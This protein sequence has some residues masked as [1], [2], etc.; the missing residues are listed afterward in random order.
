MRTPQPLCSHPVQ[1][2]SRPHSGSS[3]ASERCRR[4]AV[5]WVEDLRLWRVGDATGGSTAVEL[6][7]LG[8][9]TWS[10]RGM[11]RDWEAQ[12]GRW[13]QAPGVTEETKIENVEWAIR[14]SNPPILTGRE[15]PLEVN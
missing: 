15:G 4:P 14:A 7:G 11:P 8:A 9:P 5:G 12:L 6:G 13:A 3:S 2:F 10:G 1:P